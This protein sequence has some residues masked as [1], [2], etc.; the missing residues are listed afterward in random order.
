[1]RIDDTHR[2]W[3]AGSVIGLAVAT[4]VYVL[5]SVRSAQGPRG[6]SV[7]GLTFGIVGFSFMLFAGLLGLRKKFPIWRV[8]RAQSGC[9]PSV[10]G[11][12][13]FRSSFS[14]AAFTLTAY[15]RPDV[16][17]FLFSPARFWE[18][19]CSTHPRIHTAQLPMETVT[20]RLTGYGPVGGGSSPTGGGSLPALEA[21][22]TPKITAGHIRQCGKMG[23]LTVASGSGG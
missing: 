20:S 18:L 4:A 10:A 3:F 8:G 13:S 15:P 1:V 17:S 16:V 14:T 11:F 9:A 7:L 21:R 5:Y 12:L 6:G 22:R 23:G 19:R 2:K